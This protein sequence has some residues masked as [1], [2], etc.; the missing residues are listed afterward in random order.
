MKLIVLIVASMLCGGTYA[1]STAPVPANGQLDQI[2]ANM[3]QAGKNVKTAEAN[4]VYTKRNTQLGGSER[5][6]GWLKFRHIGQNRDLLRMKYDN[7]MEVVVDATWTYL[8]QPSIKQVTKNP[9]SSLASDSEDLSFIEIP[10]RS[11]ADLKARY[12]I[13][14]RG[15]ESVASKETSVIELIP[16]PEPGGRKTVVWVDHA[17]WLPVQYEITN[18]TSVRTFTLRDVK[19]NVELGKDVFK[20]NPPSG[21]KWVTP[22]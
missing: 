18:R 16:K 7:G 22:N 20:M 12:T 6:T 9:R 1:G 4:L 11:M 8:Y 10:Y 17:S 2:L 14:H 21:T 5:N 15:E 19:I 13:T 3:Q